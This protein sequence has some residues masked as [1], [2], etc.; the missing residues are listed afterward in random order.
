M[1]NGEYRWIDLE[2]GIQVR[3]AAP[4]DGTE[5]TYRTG[6]YWLIPARVATGTI[7]WP[8]PTP[9]P[10]RSE[11]PPHGVHHHHAPLGMVSWNATSNAWTVDNT[12]RCEFP[13]MCG[14]LIPQ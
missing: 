9:S 7:E 11:Q 14:A 8:D 2:D 12:C 1:P 13:P 5:G 3:F 10:D 6:D 4:P